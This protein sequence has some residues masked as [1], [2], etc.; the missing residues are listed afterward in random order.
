MN[1]IKAIRLEGRAVTANR[2][3]MFI[4]FLQPVLIMACLRIAGDSNFIPPGSIE[5]IRSFDYF[6]PAVL[7]I[8]LIYICAQTTMLRIVGERKAEGGTLD[9]ERLGIDNFSHFF[10]KFIANSFFAL[11][12]CTL[13]LLV[14]LILGLE[15]KGSVGIFFILLFLAA[16]FG[17]AL[18]LIVSVFA[19][20]K[21]QAAYIIP[22]IVIILMIFGD[23]IIPVS[24]MPEN[25]RSIAEHLPI[26][27]V[28]NGLTTIQNNS[29][30]E[31]NSKMIIIFIWTIILLLIGIIKYSIEKG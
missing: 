16:L 27:V 13:L 20:T 24:A 29:S 9:R 30:T 4:L 17:L 18:G 23:V 14:G 11:L 31:V 22:L 1:L 10:G 15:I 5:P 12:Q 3:A 6:A 21:L 26:T 28:Y 8:S 2:F 7:A 25:I 19:K